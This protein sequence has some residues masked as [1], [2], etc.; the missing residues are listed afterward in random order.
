M[1]HEIVF[2]N[3]TK[4]NKRKKKMKKGVFSL[5]EVCCKPEAED[6]ICF[7]TENLCR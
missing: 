4:L 6:K 5:K 2:R 7:S 3:A 1:H